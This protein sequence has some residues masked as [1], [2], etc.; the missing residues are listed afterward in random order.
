[1]RGAL[2]QRDSARPASLCSLRGHRQAE[3]CGQAR[4]KWSLVSRTH[5]VL[6]WLQREACGWVDRGSRGLRVSEESRRA[7]GAREDG[8]GRRKDLTTAG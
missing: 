8:S 7:W 5:N 1:M 6:L 4:E 3:P 2:L